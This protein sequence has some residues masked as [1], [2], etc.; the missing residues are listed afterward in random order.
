MTLESLEHLAPMAILGLW[1]L[2]LVSIA[3]WRTDAPSLHRLVALPGVVMALLAA[4][5][6]VGDPAI[7]VGVPL[8]GGAVVIDPLAALIDAALLVALLAALLSD[9]RFAEDPPALAAALVGACGLML[10]IHAA[11][12]LP[13]VAG[14]EIGALSLVVILG[15][16]PEQRPLALRWLVGQG[17]LCAAMLFGVALIVAATGTTSIAGLGGRAAMIFT[18]WG[19]GPAQ[20]A[21]DLLRSGVPIPEALEAEARTRAVTAMAPAALFLPG[22]LLTF[23]ALV[24]RF[25]AAF[26]HRLLA[27][28]YDRGSIG[29]LLLFEGG[30]RLATL[31]ALIRLFVTGL[32]VPRQLFAPYGWS[33][34]AVLLIGA[35]LLLGGVLALRARELRSWLAGQAL[36]GGGWLLLASLAAANFYAHAGLRTGAITVT[37]H[38]EWGF[39]SGDASIAALLGLGLSQTLA[40]AGLMAVLSA[41]GDP[42]ARGPLL[43]RGLA[44]RRPLLAAATTALLLALAGSPPTALFIARFE[45]LA[46]VSADTNLP[47]RLLAVLAILAAIAVTAA[48]LRFLV[49]IFTAP[50]AGGQEQDQT[51]TQGARGPT[52][53]A[54]LAALAVTLTGVAPHFVLRH[55]ELAACAVGMNPGQRSRGERLE[56]LRARW[57]GVPTEDET[58]TE[59]PAGDDARPNVAPTATLQ[60]P[61][62]VR[63]NAVEIDRMPPTQADRKRSR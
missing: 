53:I 11:D 35:T 3:R 23:G 31:V 6:L 59:A 8:L 5:S 28:L 55:L 50:P 17:I 56:A 21:V 22:M 41:L 33:S 42:R 36:V 39:A 25:G 62:P 58:E 15:R 57:S 51:Q 26:G 49:A 19:A 52:A 12:L 32:H 18:R 38:H 54:V 20:V 45:L 34:P 24:L 2:L 13:L 4:L 47:V 30:L 10:T 60:T 43:L 27:G 16:D 46:A 9:R 61:S 14:L 44:A 37:D 1:S 48:A 40:S 63:E 7:D 29:S